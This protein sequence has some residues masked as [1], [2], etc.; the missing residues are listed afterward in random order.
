MK[1]ALEHS[2][3]FG[4]FFLKKMLDFCNTKYIIYLCGAKAR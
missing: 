1:R 3:V 2:F 4:C